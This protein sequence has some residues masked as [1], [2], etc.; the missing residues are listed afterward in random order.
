[1]YRCQFTLVLSFFSKDF[2]V[3]V[4]YLFKDKLETL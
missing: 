2:S 4:V 3:A 1:M